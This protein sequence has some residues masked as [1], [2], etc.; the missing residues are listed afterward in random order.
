MHKLLI[1]IFMSISL[2]SEIIKPHREFK[3]NGFVYDFIISGEKLYSATGVGEVDIFSLKSGN[4]IDIIK[5]PSIPSFYEEESFAKIYSV[6]VFQ[7]LV[8]ILSEGEYGSRKIFLKNKDKLERL[9][10]SP[11]PIKKA[12][13]I[14]DV[15]FLYG[16]LANEIVLYDIVNH[17]EV[18]RKQVNSSPFSDF[19]IYGEE[20]AVASE[21]GDIS[22]HNIWTGEIIKTLKG[23]NLDNVYKVAFENQTILGAGQDRQISIYK[24]NDKSYNQKGEFLIYSV[25]LSQNEK[26]GAYPFNQENDIRIFNVENRDILHV[27]KGQ[28]STLNTMEFKNENTL[29]TSSNDEYI[30]EW[31]FK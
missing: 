4:I 19:D 3:A 10:S 12:K 29:F 9:F 8:L 6:D 7:D 30:L 17:R 20:V 18:Y 15:L 1:L 27:L 22:I 21:S 24:L 26:I 23:Q 28:K 5:V 31:R 25:A 13:F 2:F 16:T 11:S 14:N